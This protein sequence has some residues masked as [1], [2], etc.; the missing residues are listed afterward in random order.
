MGIEDMGEIQRNVEEEAERVAKEKAE[1]AAAKEAQQQAE[2][3][4]IREAA[5][6][7]GEIQDA[8]KRQSERRYKSD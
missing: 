6:V 3:D 5:R 8:L 2:I 4:K 1:A 7:E